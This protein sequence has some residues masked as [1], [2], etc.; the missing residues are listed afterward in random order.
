MRLTTKHVTALENVLAH[1][2]A[3]LDGQNVFG[4]EE[5]GQLTKDLAVGIIALAALRLEVCSPPRTRPFAPRKRAAP[6][7]ARPRRRR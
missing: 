7:V 2:Q 6:G 1:A 4:P 5:V 3:V